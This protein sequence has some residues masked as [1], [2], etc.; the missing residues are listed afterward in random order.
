MAR[1]EGIIIRNFGVLREVDLLDLTSLTA[2]IGKN[3]V[4][5]STLFDAFGFLADCLRLGVEEA[6]YARGRGGFERIRSKGRE[7]PIELA[8]V[9]CEDASDGGLVFHLAI[10][11][12][13]DGRPFVFR[14]MFARVWPGQK[15]DPWSVFLALRSGKGLAWKGEKGGE[16]VEQARGGFDIEFD[17]LLDIIR[18]GR[19]KENPNAEPVELSDPR[20]LGIAT[21]GA[22]KQHPRIA[23][24]RQFMEGWYLSY[25]EPNAARELPLAGPQK[26]LNSRGDNL[27]NMVQFMEREHKGRLQGILDRIAARIPG[28]HQIDTHRTEDNRLL[29]RFNDKGFVDPFYAQQVS[30]GTLK[31]FAYLLL[32]EDPAPPPFLCIEEPENGL[33]HKLLETLAREFRE[34]ANRGGSQI[35]VT[36]HQPYLV[37]ALDPKEVWILEKGEDGFATIRRASDDPV[38]RSMVE[39]GLP[40]GGLWYSDYLDAR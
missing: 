5:K 22:L 40:L 2:V 21:L 36:T 25:F 23:R 1:I 14:E 13:E 19:W 38:V 3:G 20:R 29:L 33:Y 7:D 4:G 10:D 8:V 16:Q 6:C 18:E 30:D 12:D 27:G 9:Y 17:A 26:H 24:F 15:D 32:L 37:D 35:L 11:S 34:H 31:V 39:E 28:I